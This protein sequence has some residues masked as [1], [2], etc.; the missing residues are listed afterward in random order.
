[1]PAAKTGKPSSSILRTSRTS[2]STIAPRAP[3]AL[4]AVD[5]SSPQGAFRVDFPVPTT[6]TSPGSRLSTASISSEYGSAGMW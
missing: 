6:A 3:R 4:D 1:M 2:P 5:K